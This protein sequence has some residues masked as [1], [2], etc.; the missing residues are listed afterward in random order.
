MEGRGVSDG[1]W[2]VVFAERHGHNIIIYVDDGDGW[3]RNESLASLLGP[4]RGGR[5]SPPPP[6]LVDKHEG[7]TVGGRPEVA[8]AKLLAVKEDLVDGE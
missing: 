2:H 3:R 6:L 8:G 7:L 1:E 4:E 5:L